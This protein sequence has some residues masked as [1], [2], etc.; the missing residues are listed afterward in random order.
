M[1]PILRPDLWGGMASLLHLAAATA[2]ACVAFWIVR[3]RRVSGLPHPGATVAALATAALWSLAMAVSG[4]GSVVAVIALALRNLADLALLR[5]L[6]ASD[7]RDASVA[8]VRPVVLVLAGVA[9]LQ[10]IA[11]VLSAR[12]HEALLADVGTVLALLGVVGALVLLHNLYA[13]ADAAARHGLRWPTVALALLWCFDLNLYTVAWVAHGWPREVAAL[14]GVVDIAFA[15]ALLVGAAQRGEPLLLRPSRTVTFHSLSLLLIGAYLLVMVAVAQWLA[16]AGGDYA[17]WLQYGFLLVAASGAVLALPSRR[18]RTWLRVML[19]KHMFQHRYD[20]RAEW[21]RFTRTMGRAG[22]DAPPL[23]ERAIRALADITASPAGLLLVLGED[24]D[25]VLAARWQ[26]PEVEVPPRALSA[27]VVA[28]LEAHD[29]IVDLGQAT[30]AGPDL[31]GWLRADP[32]GWAMVPLL[33]YERL[34]GAVVLARPP[35]ERRLD[36]EDFDLLRVAGQQCASYLAEQAGAQALAEAARFDDFN[37]R[38][39]FV[40]HDIKNLASQFGLLAHNAERHAENPAFRADMLVTLRASA[41]KLSALTARLSRY[42]GGVVERIGPVVLVPLVETALARHPVRVIVRDACTVAGNAPAIEQ[43]LLHLVQNAI[44]ASPPETPIFVAISAAAPWAQIEVIDQGHGM[45]P[46][47]IR[48]RL[49]RPF[50]SSKPGG[51]GIG[52]CE[53]RDLVRAMHGRLEVESRE[54][55]GTRFVIRLPLATDN[56]SAEA[57]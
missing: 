19:A 1:I 6:F 51:F 25:L 36:W 14:H 27:A 10:P 31:P 9:L 26:W 16:D 55:I 11:A 33:H 5:A 4:A 37:R 13:G 28:Y 12:A 20:Y 40:M 3:Q 38:I 24:G 45:S 56:R 7:G 47:F 8:P 22:A 53:A 2:A 30:Y 39:A 34:V 42:G 43:V 35:Q 18:G 46:D 23:H 49:F 17:R 29:F 21:L 15:L 41:D 54:G 48:T 52:A 57:A 50:D 32:R 44:D